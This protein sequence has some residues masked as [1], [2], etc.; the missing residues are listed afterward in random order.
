MSGFEALLLFY[1]LM[2]AHFNA[3]FVGHC[4]GSKGKEEEPFWLATEITG[5][6]LGIFWPIVIIWDLC[7]KV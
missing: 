4:Y 7:K 1:I 2:G 6:L 5:L 3:F